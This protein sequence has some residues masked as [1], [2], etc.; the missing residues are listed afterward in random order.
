MEQKS[1]K[2]W[3]ATDEDG[4]TSIYNKPPIWNFN[5]WRPRK[6]GY[7]TKISSEFF[8]HLFPFPAP[9]WEDEPIQIEITIKKA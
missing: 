7:K 4:E 1:I 3:V 6:A 8:K 2:A 9:T 5:Y